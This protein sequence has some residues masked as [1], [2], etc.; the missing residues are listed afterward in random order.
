M[1]R[2]GCDDASEYCKSGY[3]KYCLKDF[4]GALADFTEAIERKPCCGSA[5]NNRGMIY[6]FLKQTIEAVSDFR[7]A[8]DL[9]FPVDMKHLNLLN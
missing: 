9:G 7:K 1:R 5:Y 4:H 2:D 3:K 8:K 6:L